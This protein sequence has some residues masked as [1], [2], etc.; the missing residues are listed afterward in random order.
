MQRPYQ[1]LTDEELMQHLAAGVEEAL[2][3]LHGRYAPLIFTMAAQSLGYDA[4]EEIVQDVLLVVWRKAAT[5][6]PARGAFRHWV[7]RIAHLRIIN[8]LR[9]RGHRPQIAPDPDGLHLASL[10]GDDPGPDE[11]AWRAYRRSAVRE[12]V[13]ALP[14]PQRQALSLA[15]FEELTHA[16]I[17]SYLDLP[18]GT[19]K[20]RIRAGL[21]KMRVYLTRSM[22]IVLTLLGGLLIALGLRDHTVQQA[23]VARDNRALQ[24]VTA[25]DVVALRLA[26]T[27]GVPAETHGVYR[28]RPGGDIAIA[29]FEHFAPAPVGQ[30]YRAWAL[31]DGRWTS[32]GTVRPDGNGNALVILEGPDVAVSPEILQVTL[33]P[34]TDGAAPTGRV[35]IIWPGP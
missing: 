23:A 24:M 29:T 5:F 14:P 17:A 13:E 11:E 19:A 31:R 16:Q 4:A 32:L 2:A 25:S 34:T 21:Q 8:E 28:S 9:R 35:I 1:D 15:F 10:P 27:T 6:D 26:P 22:L 18:L 3:P 12:A 7:L 33:E 30:T 20:S